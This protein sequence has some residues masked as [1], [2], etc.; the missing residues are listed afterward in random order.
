MVCT[1]KLIPTIFSFQKSKS[2]MLKTGVFPAINK[3]IILEALDINSFVLEIS[4]EKE[5]L[6]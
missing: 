4:W 1:P 5:L 2:S 3:G 6:E